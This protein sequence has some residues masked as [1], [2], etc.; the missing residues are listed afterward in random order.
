MEKSSSLQEN[1]N[2]KA[3]L[4]VH[5]AVVLF[6]IVG[7][8]AKLVDLPAVII[9][10]GRVCFS[11]IFLWIFLII[12]KQKIRL[13]VR[14]DYIL[15]AVAGIILAAHWTSF[16]QSIQSS[17]VAIGTLTFSTFPLFVTFLEP[18]IFRERLKIGD[19]I[20]AVIMLIGV[21][22]I[23]PEFQ[24][25]N[26]MTQGVIWG[27]ISALTYAALSLMN[28]SLADRYSGTVT[29]FYEQA[30]ATVV[31][32]PAIFI[33]RPQIG[34]SDVEVLIILGVFFTGLSH[35]LFIS[36]L[37][38]VKVR[39]AGIISGLE[40]VYGIVGAFLVLGEVP[41]IR[42]IL[43]GSIILGVVFYSTVHSSNKEEAEK[44]RMI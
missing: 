18:Y 24:L 33:L 36:G 4:S 22:L 32:L 28:R 17:T 41:G 3:L 29:A 20:C 7:L 40:S 37:K 43:G 14:R 11:S 8:F 5:L 10:L 34:L 6:G 9:V 1:K 26:H 30:A 16:M 19:V 31:L 12:R 44:E 25:D 13:E 38:R 15:M 35:S 2:K 21:L 27:L 42:E 39:T 23:V